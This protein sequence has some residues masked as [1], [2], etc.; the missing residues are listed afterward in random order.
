[1]RYYSPFEYLL[2]SLG[3]AAGLD[4]LLFEERIQWCLNQGKNLRSLVHEADEPAL[5]LR[6]VQELQRLVAGEI[7]SQYTMA[8]DATSSGLQL[9]ACLSG[10]V[11]T[12]AQ[13]GLVNPEERSDAYTKLAEVM[14]KYLPPERHIGINPDGFTR[15]DLKEPFMTHW[16]A[17][18]AQPKSVFG[19][20]TPELQAFYSACDEMAPGAGK[21]LEDFLGCIDEDRT[22][23]SWIMPDGFD[24]RT[25][26]IIPIDIKVELQE[27]LTEGGN[28][29]TFT[30][31][32]Y[33]Q[34]E[35]P[36]YVAIAANVTHSCDGLLVREIKRR[37]GYDRTN[38][39]KVL[40][41]MKDAGVSANLY[42]SERF[43][44]IRAIE[45]WQTL[46]K[47]HQQKLR[48]I[49]EQVV[50]YP[51]YDIITVHDAFGNSPVHMNMTR[52][53][54]TELLAEIAESDL[55]QEIL[56]QV[57]RDNTLIYEKEGDGTLLAATIRKNSNYALS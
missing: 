39:S 55:C 30:H 11:T 10:C 41:S 6:A 37:A 22:E 31:R 38:L 52:Y 34:G 13:C 18:V 2:I 23:Y 40:E 5:Y 16:Y 51:A 44:S 17:S 15:Q 25:K 12:A 46:P 42:A 48:A 21:L 50:N 3:N 27:L 54:Y 24:V 36:A 4:K 19:E 14:N 28:P 56:R 9:L 45:S 1:M 43:I 8:L 53:L 57:Y 32:V 33:R 20:G 35:N 26:V 7:N 47:A 49:I 29:A